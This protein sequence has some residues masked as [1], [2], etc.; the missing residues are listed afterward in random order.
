MRGDIQIELWHTSQRRTL[1]GLFMSERWVIVSVLALIGLVF[2][3][4]GCKG[5]KKQAA[6]A[7]D[8]LRQIHYS[9]C[10]EHE[11]TPEDVPACERA[12]ARLRVLEPSIE[13][14][15]A[16]HAA[17][18]E[19]WTYARPYIEGLARQALAM[20]APWVLSQLPVMAGG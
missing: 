12:Y 3:L 5:V 16:S 11:P 9:M 18:R 20:V 1:P 7:L 6:S 13:D 10:I 8:E 14:A 4:F 2:G 15:L 17:L 19:A